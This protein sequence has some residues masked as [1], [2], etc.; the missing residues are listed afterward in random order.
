MV[1]PI[2]T[3]NLPHSLIMSQMA[4]GREKRILSLLLQAWLSASLV[5]RSVLSVPEKPEQT[6]H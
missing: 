5:P 1:P 4:S 6:R 2:H 3:T